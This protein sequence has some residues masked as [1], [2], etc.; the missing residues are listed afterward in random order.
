MIIGF[1]IVFCL[2]VSF[3]SAGFLGDFLTEFTGIGSPEIVYSSAPE[4]VNQGEVFEIGCDFGEVLPC[5]GAV[6][7]GRGCVYKTFEGNSAIFECNATES[8]VQENYCNLWIYEPDERCHEIQ[9]NKIGDTEVLGGAGEEEKICTDSDGNL[10]LE[11][12]YYVRGTL[13]SDWE[14]LSGTDTCVEIDW[15]LTDS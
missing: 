4:S 9:Q 15:A 1:V 14:D 12:S 3:A 6:H 8:G 5:I 7:A 2:L 13:E 10:S 11:D